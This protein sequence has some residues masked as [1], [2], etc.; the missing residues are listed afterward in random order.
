M[1]CT[2]GTATAT[3]P[4]RQGE[5]LTFVLAQ[6]SAWEPPPTPWSARAIRSGLHVTEK[7]W[8]SW[9][10]LHQRYERAVGRTGTWS[11]AAASCCRA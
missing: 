2:A 8:Q 1:D 6:S 11:T 7:A 10:H 3:T 9:S 5:D 4:L